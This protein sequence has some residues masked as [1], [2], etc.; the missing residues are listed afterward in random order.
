MLFHDLE[1]ILDEGV[2]SC[3]CLS[4]E[5]QPQAFL[6]VSRLCELRISTFFKLLGWSVSDDKDLPFSTIAK[7]SGPD[8]NLSEAHLG[9]SAAAEHGQT[10]GG[11]GRG[12]PRPHR[13]KED[14][15]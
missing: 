3:L 1:L 11:T 2:A 12:L 5:M 4:V 10:P 14:G 13:P 7:L 15:S 6:F 8:V 9:L